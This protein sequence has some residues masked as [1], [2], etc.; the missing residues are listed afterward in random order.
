[1][2]RTATTTPSLLTR[3]VLD[4]ISLRRLGL[5]ALELD[6]A[7]SDYIAGVNRSPLEITV[8]DVSR[9]LNATYGET[10][11]SA[12]AREVHGA[13]LGFI[14]R[15]PA[16]SV[17]RISIAEQRPAL[18]D[19]LGRIL[20]NEY[21]ALPDC[22]FTEDVGTLFSAIEVRIFG[23]SGDEFFY[24]DH[25]D[26]RPPD[27]VASRV[28][29][30]IQEELART[31]ESGPDSL[32]VAPDQ[33]DDPGF[34]RAME[35][36]SRALAATAWWWPALLLVLAVALALA[37]QATGALG[38]I[39]L[40]F[41]FG[42]VCYGIVAITVAPGRIESALAG[43][44]T[45]GEASEVWATLGIYGFRRVAEVSG[46]WAII[47]GAIAITASLALPPAVG[48]LRSPRES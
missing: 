36:A 13:L 47:A 48:R 18:A 45:V 43:R 4:P 12:K 7:N 14:D 31:A 27:V 17:F 26:C 8:E 23:G 19:S 44:G 37:V 21:R 11:T 39:G 41:G 20:L 10:E 1:M 22:G 15:Y 25:P 34:T 35:T 5:R 2:A 24:E 9:V 38:R 42:L 28:E 6:I 30:G 29:T 33:P 46:W 40:G 3:T 16:D 32:D